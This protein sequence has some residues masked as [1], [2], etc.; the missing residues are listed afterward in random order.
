MTSHVVRFLRCIDLCGQGFTLVTE[1]VDYLEKCSMAETPEHWLNW[2]YPST[3]SQSLGLA[4][5]TT[6][7]W[8]TERPV[9]AKMH[10]WHRTM[11]SAPKRQIQSSRRHRCMGYPIE[12]KD[13]T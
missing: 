2:R 12:S 7:N 3:R 4:G 6:G 10:A 11:T 13:S 1:N 5:R 8:T 9:I